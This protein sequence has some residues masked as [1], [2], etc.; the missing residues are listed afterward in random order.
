MA[1]ATD[2]AEALEGSSAVCEIPAE[3]CAIVIYGASG[4]LAR[5]KLLPALY[6]LAARACLA[7]NFVILGF[8][9]T[10]M[11]DDAFR[12][13]AGQAV[14]PPAVVAPEDEAKWRAFA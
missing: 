14:R 1:E 11:S 8:A 12:D 5:R 7:Q 10:P 3:P 6:D 9:R 13:L 2:L 4:D